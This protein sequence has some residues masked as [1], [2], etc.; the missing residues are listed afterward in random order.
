M[1][2][3]ALLLAVILGTVVFGGLHAQTNTTNTPSN[4]SSLTTPNRLKINLTLG[5]P[6]N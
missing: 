6:R 4:N 2:W 5:D 3:R 1:N